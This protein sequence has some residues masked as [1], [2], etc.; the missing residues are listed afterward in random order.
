MHGV[1][2]DGDMTR[3]DELIRL[4]EAALRGPALAEVLGPPETYEDAE[5]YLGTAAVDAAYNALCSI[6]QLEPTNDPDPT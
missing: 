2:E 5:A 3:R 1:R 4:T 6:D